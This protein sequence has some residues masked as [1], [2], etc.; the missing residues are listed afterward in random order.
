MKRLVQPSNSFKMPSGPA[1]VSVAR[2]TVAPMAQTRFPFAFD[3]LTRRHASSSTN[4][5]SESHLC[6]V[7]SSTSIWRKLP[8]PTCSV[9][10]AWL[11]PAISMRFISSREKWRPV[12]GAVTAPSFEAKIVWKFSISSGIACRMW[13]TSSG[14]GASPKA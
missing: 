7:R 13:R 12:T 1:A 10:K 4:I 3:S 6:L 5:C 14:I 8:S 2:N 9:M 11:M